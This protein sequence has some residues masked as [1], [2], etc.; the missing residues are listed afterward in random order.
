MVKSVTEKVECQ[1][2]DRYFFRNHEGRIFKYRQFC[3]RKGCLTESSYNYQDLKTKYCFRH[4]EENM[5]NVK[6]HHKLC[7]TCKSFYK[8]SCVSPSCKYTI[9][10]YKNQSVYMKLKTINYLK[11]TKQ[12]FYLCRL[13]QQIV[14]REHFE[15][16]EHIDLFNSVVDIEINQSLKNSFLSIKTMFMNTNYNNIYT[17]LYFKKRIKK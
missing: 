12:E 13:C 6:R 1:R 17:D 14:S 15:T 8:T 2:I 5:I 9:D 16:Q 3:K 10:N 11:E 4:K 7:K